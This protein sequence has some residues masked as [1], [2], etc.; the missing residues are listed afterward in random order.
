MDKYVFVL[1]FYPKSVSIL[2]LRNILK[3]QKSVGFRGHKQYAA[4]YLASLMKIVKQ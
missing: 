3:E 1:N 2:Y 4:Q